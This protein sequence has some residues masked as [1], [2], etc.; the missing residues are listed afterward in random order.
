MKSSSLFLNSFKATCFA[1]GTLISASSLAAAV[2]LEGDDLI[3][4]FD[5]SSLFGTANVIGN[6]LFFLPTDF[7]SESTGIAS[8]N[9]VTETLNIRISVKEGSDYIIDS[10]GIAESGDY[11]LSGEG[12][13]VSASLR[14]Q[15]TSL[16]QTD[17]G[18][19]FGSGPLTNVELVQTGPI[20]APNDSSTNNW[21][22]LNINDFVWGEETD[23]NLQLQNNLIADTDNADELAFI[24]KKSGAIGVFV[25]PIPLP[26]AFWFFAS[27][28]G[29][30]IAFSRKVRRNTI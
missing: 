29:G 27:A 1:L 18:G 13:E 7:E 2:Q 23:I 15:V 3:F 4:E 26:A 10:V 9:L 21:D 16:T 12:A 25:N 28:L 22:L 5:D 24:Q 8:P 14:S 19:L 6:N 17:P 11:I 30:L 20:T